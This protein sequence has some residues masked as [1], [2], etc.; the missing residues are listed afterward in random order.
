MTLK[1]Y[2]PQKNNP[3]PSADNL[4]PYETWVHYMETQ[5]AEKIVSLY[6]PESFLLPTFAQT[7]LTTQEGRLDYFAQLKKQPFHITTQVRH[8]L[9]IEEHIMV[10]SGYYTFHL[11]DN[12]EQVD[13]SV[14]FTFVFKKDHPD[15]NWLIKLH[16]S[17]LA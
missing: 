1:A 5:T 14:R 12:G 3:S 13:R 6:H 17:S 9:F 7:I 10:N 8:E 11:Q 16:Q 4:T 15:A 2:P